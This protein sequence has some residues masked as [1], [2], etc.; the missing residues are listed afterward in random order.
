MSTALNN[1]GLIPLGDDNNQFLLSKLNATE[2]LALDRH[3]VKNHEEKA[4]MHE[5]AYM[6]TD[7]TTGSQ[8]VLAAA[9][10]MNGIELNNKSTADIDFIGVEFKN[11]SIVN[12]DKDVF[13]AVGLNKDDFENV[14]GSPLTIRNEFG[15]IQAARDAAS[16]RVHPNTITKKL[17]E[18]QARLSNA[19]TQ[20]SMESPDAR[21]RLREQNALREAIAERRELLISNIEADNYG[22]ASSNDKKELFMLSVKPESQTLDQDGN[23]RN[24]IDTEREYNGRFAAVPAGGFMELGDTDGNFLIGKPREEQLAM[25]KTRVGSDILINA[26]TIRQKDGNGT[27]LIYAATDKEHNTGRFDALYISD[28]NMV[29]SQGK[30]AFA[31]VGIDSG[32]LNQGHKWG[33]VEKGDATNSQLNQTKFYSQVSPNN[34]RQMV[35]KNQIRQY[36]KDIGNDIARNGFDESLLVNPRISD[37]AAEK[38]RKGGVRGLAVDEATAKAIARATFHDRHEVI[39]LNS[40]QIEDFKVYTGIDNTGDKVVLLTENHAD[41]SN[42]IKNPGPVDSMRAIFAPDTEARSL[43]IN[44]AGDFQHVDLARNDRNHSLVIKTYQGAAHQDEIKPPYEFPEVS[45]ESVVSAAINSF[46]TVVRYDENSPQIKGVEGKVERHKVMD[47]VDFIKQIA[48]GD[49]PTPPTTIAPTNR[50]KM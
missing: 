36:Q 34:L 22:V 32:K 8:Y 47:H 48:R 21:S 10:R 45:A 35:A 19:A 27:T 41:N 25:L 46:N 17:R 23:L 50:N 24:H 1:G 37:A 14:Q 39:T 28:F 16:N 20:T 12:K 49:D 18:E 15:V 33:D 7:K 4:I 9:W 5:S 26:T 42:E 29:L 31:A 30:E 40:S 44:G 13:K 6:L 11:G 43:K 38:L 3:A 2:K